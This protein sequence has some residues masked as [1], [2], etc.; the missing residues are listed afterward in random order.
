M[1]MK[2]SFPLIVLLYFAFAKQ[3]HAC[4]CTSYW[5]TKEKIENSN[6]VAL[7]K[8]IDIV[9]ANTRKYH[10][11]KVT[12]LILYKGKSVSEIIV[13]GGSRAIDSTYWSS[14]DLGIENGQEWIIYGHKK[15]DDIE[16]GFC[17]DPMFYKNKDGYRDLNLGFKI[18]ELNEVNS[19]F[20]KPVLTFTKKMAPLNC[21]T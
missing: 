11:I 18:K 19:Y 2:I 15:G 9:S 12:E 16:I 6:Y 1:I 5:N 14:C 7:V 17:S 20:S 4:S 21:I 13:A 10:K 8:V 3:A